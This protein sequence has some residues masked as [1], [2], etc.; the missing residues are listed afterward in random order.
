M[1][2]TGD[3]NLLVAARSALLDALE[4][5]RAQLDA[6]IVVGAQAVYL[7][8]GE[9]QV[10]LAAATKDSDL[11]LNPPILADHPLLEQAMT[12]AGFRLD[13]NSRQP[14]AWL[15]REGVPVDLMVPEALAGAG[16]RPT[17]ASRHLRRPQLDAL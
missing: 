5:L 15:N 17:P 4:A 14:G 7:H 9:T 1:S 6:V 12:A 2:Q 10:A 13:P 11:A 3:A 16:G 8:T